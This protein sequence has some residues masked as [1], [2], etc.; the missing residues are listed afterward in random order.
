VT[1]F[2]LS[3]LCCKVLG[4]YLGLTN[5]QMAALHLG[6][7]PMLS[8]TEGMAVYTLM[9]CVANGIGIVIS[10]CLWIFADAIALRMGG[11]DTRSNAGLTVSAPQFQSIAFSVIGLVLLTKAIP[12]IIRAVIDETLKNGFTHLQYFGGGSKRGPAE[13]SDFVFLGAQTLIGLVLLI[14][15]ARL[16]KFVNS[17]RDVGERSAT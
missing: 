6:S 16:V 1:R 11:P 2:Q 10:V 7:L 15:S 14:G 4:L 9:A 8:R 3:V 13:I 5:L 17:V 12:N